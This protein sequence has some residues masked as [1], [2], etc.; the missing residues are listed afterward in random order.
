MVLASMELQVL[1]RTP[2]EAAVEVA[3]A[4]EAATESREVAVVA[5]EVA[6]VVTEVAV[7]ATEVAV[8]ATERAAVVATEVAVVVKDVVLALRV[9]PA[10]V[11]EDQE[12]KVTDPELK[13]VLAAVREDPDLPEL[14]VVRVLLLRVAMR[15][16]S[17]ARERKETLIMLSTVSRVRRESSSTP[18]IEETEPAEA[19]VL[20]RV[21]TVRETGVPLRMILRPLM[22]LLRRPQRPLSSLLLRSL[23][24][25]KSLTRKRR[26]QLRRESQLRMNSMLRNSPLLSTW[27]RRRNPPSRRR[28]ELTTQSL[29]RRLTLS[30]KL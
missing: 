2:A 3:V 22:R 13:V 24:L 29:L 17:T 11:K 27:H 8:E 12:R 20:P 4:I 21:A 15:V 14:R 10:G 1:R 23:R 26:P 7:E 5:I 30:S 19:E 25:K 6:A 18:S 16:S 28:L 9:V